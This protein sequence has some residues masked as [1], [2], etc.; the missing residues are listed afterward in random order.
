MKR[1]FLGLLLAVAAALSA[2]LAYAQERIATFAVSFKLHLKAYG[3][4]LSLHLENWMARQGLILGVNTITNLIPTM[5]EALDVVSRE[6]VGFISAVSRNSGLARVA[7]NQTVNIPIVPPIVGGNVTPGATPPNDGDAV[8]GN[9][10]MTISKSRYWPVRWNGEEQLAVSSS[11]MYPNVIRDQFA[12]AF[13]AA[14]NEIEVDL[15]ALYVA[16][17]RSFGT[18]GAAPFATNAVFTDF[19]G[20]LR[21][22]EDNGAPG[23]KQLVLG[24][25]AIANI[26][27]IQ[28]IL[29]K[30]NEAGTSDLLRQGIIGQVEGLNIHNSSAIRP[31]A[32][33]T[34]AAYT[35]TNAG[36]PIGTTSIPIITG[37]G[38]VLAGDNITFAGD[39]NIYV[40]TT[41]VAAPGTI[42]IGAPGLRVA[43][44]AVATA[45]AIGAISTR[46]MGFARSAIQLATRAPALPEGGDMADDRTFV[47]DPITGLSFE[48]SLYRQYRQVKYEVAMAWGQKMVTPAHSMNLL[49]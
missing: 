46:N 25:A 30:A 36:F 10:T 3:Y 39:T 9:T 31:V 16:S 45:M 44:P 27:G 32:V 37:A 38:T 23:D 48:V 33:G 42:T 5:Y 17:S 43:I 35:S 2:P 22:L 18:A 29:F 7:L 13:R 49:G 11:G 6:Q 12:Q 15:A 1:L 41:G 24:S 28:S 26:R 21:I 8:F 14:C 4:I 19:A 20:V 40:V 34:G 47:T